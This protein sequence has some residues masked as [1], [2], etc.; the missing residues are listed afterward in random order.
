MSQPAGN[1]QITGARAISCQGERQKR[2]YQ[3]NV[4]GTLRVPDPHTECAVYFFL[5]L[6]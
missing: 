2:T 5:P 6:A 1:R 4:V 3:H